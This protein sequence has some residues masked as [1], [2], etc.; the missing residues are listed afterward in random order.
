M[1]LATTRDSF[2]IE[3]IDSASR[4]VSSIITTAAEKT[5]RKAKTPTCSQN[6]R[7]QYAKHFDIDCKKLLSQVK[8]MSKK[9]SREP[10]NFFLRKS[11]YSNKKL[12]HRLVKTKV[13]C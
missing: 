7:K 12:L 8:Q 3:D 6:R 10:K 9:L 1:E 11:Y 5:F 4:A 13:G 2:N